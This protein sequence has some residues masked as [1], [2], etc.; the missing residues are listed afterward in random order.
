MEGV[1]VNLKKPMRNIPERSKFSVAITSRVVTILYL[2]SSLRGLGR[3]LKGV[4]V[5]CGCS[6]RPMAM[7]SLKIR[8]TL[9]LL[10]GRTIGPGLIR[11]VRRAP[12]LIRNNPFTGV[13]RKYGDIVTA[14]TTSGLTSCMIA[15]T[16]FNTSLNTRGFLG[17]GTEARN[18]SPRTIIVMTAVHTLGVRNNLSGTRLNGRSART[19]AGNFTGLG[20]R[21]RAVRDFNLPCMITVGQFV[22]SDRGRV[23]I[24]A[25][26]YDRTNVPT[27]LARI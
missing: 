27:T 18:V 24:L 5:T 23:R 2:T 21:V 4:I 22:S 19:L 25:R 12:T 1:I 14:T 13:T 3:E 6:G 9:A 11:A 8:K 17:V 15:R 26:L 7:T 20:G 10:L 16:N